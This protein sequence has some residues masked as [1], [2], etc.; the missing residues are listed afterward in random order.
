M[1]VT[2]LGGAFCRAVDVIH[3]AR[4]IFLCDL[5]EVV[6]DFIIVADR[7]F[8][9]PGHFGYGLYRFRGRWYGYL[10]DQAACER[11]E[12]ARFK[13]GSALAK[14]SGSGT[15]RGLA[16]ASQIFVAN[17]QIGFR[18]WIPS[19]FIHRIYG[20]LIQLAPPL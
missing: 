10:Q 14:V 9:Y 16:C 19:S 11:Y 2:L 18:S 12:L 4:L 7:K 17:G 15:D 20:S 3:Y 8:L 1:A 13:T 6:A 5:K